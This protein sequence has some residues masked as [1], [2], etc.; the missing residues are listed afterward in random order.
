MYSGDLIM[1]IPFNDET[2]KIY[3]TY[4]LIAKQIMKDQKLVE[5]L[6][7]KNLRHT[8]FEKQSKAN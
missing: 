2:K 4:A 5:R 1:I 3:E 7:G 6:V 8:G